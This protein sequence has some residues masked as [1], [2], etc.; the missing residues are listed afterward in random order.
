MPR[1]PIRLFNAK[2]LAQELGRKELSPRVLGYY[3]AASF[4]IFILLGYSG[5]YF[6]SSILSW[7][8]LYY[9]LVVD[10][11]SSPLL[12]LSWLSL[13]ECFAVVAITVWGFSA[14]YFASGGDENP[15]F[16]TEFTCLFVP[17]FFTTTL[18][19]WTIY[20]GIS[21]V[22]YYYDLY[23]Y[24]FFS[25]LRSIGSSIGAD[26]YG[27]LT[28]LAVVSTQAIGFYRITKLFRIVRSVKSSTT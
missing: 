27:L 2:R 15:N 19:V 11:S 17:V 4:L 26:P 24:Q 16:I 25:N 7:P 8:N 21:F 22:L 18:V 20:W 3:L 5:F 12:F 13:Y 1:L 9:N 14:S 23:N 6:A 28:F 10:T